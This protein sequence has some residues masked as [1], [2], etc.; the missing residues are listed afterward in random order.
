MPTWIGAQNVPS[1]LLHTEGCTKYQEYQD[2][3][4]KDYCCMNQKVHYIIMKSYSHIAVII[5]I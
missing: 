1:C 5:L 2:N 3:N 4:M